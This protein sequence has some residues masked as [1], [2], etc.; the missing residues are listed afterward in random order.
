[1]K[2]L[3][4]ILVLILT[5]A[6]CF[7]NGENSSGNADKS[8]SI[9]RDTTIT[10]F[11]KRTKGVVAM[12]GGYSIPL[13]NN[14]VLWVF[15][16]SYIDHYDSVTHTVPC[17]FQVRNSALLQPRGNWQWQQTKTLLSS[18]PGVKSFLK[19]T[20]EP[21]HFIWPS[22]GI[23]LGDTAYV[24]CN[25][26]KN[27]GKGLGFGNAGP[28]MWGKIKVPEMEVVG[29]ST[30]QDFG[31][32]GFGIGFIKSNSGKY[33]YVYGSRMAKDTLANN[34]YVARFPAD[35]PNAKWEF[36]TS[37]GWDFNQDSIAPIANVPGFSWHIDK[38]KN[39]YI[40]VSAEFSLECDQGKEIYSAFSNSPTGPFSKRKTIYT[41]DDTIQGHYPFFY[42]VM[43]HPEY[44]NHKD[45]VLITYCI[46][47][48]K[49][50]I[51]NCVNNRLNPDYYR[52]QAI[53]V[54]IKIIDPDL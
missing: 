21:K 44:T 13:S 15:G 47:G 1:M 12:D 37:A 45:E 29:F 30:L 11:F 27:T 33:V 22:S 20:T 16:D 9:Y 32:V 40:L 36:W 4:A 23:Q 10:N 46:N 19:D 28:P 24:F 38:V 18:G 5:Y 42:G 8:L 39:K 17:I 41:I 14:K 54:P 52:L 35:N 31:D 48:Y 3:S 43:L 6:G 50:C 53:R 34:I 25:D 7:H 26:L 49:P 2:I 51:E